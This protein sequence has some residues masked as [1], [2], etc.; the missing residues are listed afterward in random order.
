MR[1]GARCCP[2]AVRKE[3]ARCTAAIVSET[4]QEVVGGEIRTHG[5]VP[6]HAFKAYAIDHSAISPFR[7]NNL[8]RL[9]FAI[10]PIVIGL[11]IFRDHLRPGVHFSEGR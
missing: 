2:E 10:P 6:L 5:R 3:N 7:I 9:E 4:T 1:F 11:L 8:R